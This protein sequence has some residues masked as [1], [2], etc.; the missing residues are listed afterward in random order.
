MFEKKN[1]EGYITTPVAP[2]IPIY[3]CKHSKNYFFEGHLMVEGGHL[4]TASSSIPSS[5]PAL[6]EEKPTYDKVATVPES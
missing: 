6:E 5:A 1:W 2:K 3:N 4:L